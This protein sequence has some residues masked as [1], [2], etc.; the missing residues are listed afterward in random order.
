MSNI[1][2]T[3]W[4]KVDNLKD[5]D[6]DYSDNPEV[7]DEM[8][9]LMQFREPEKK[10]IYIKLDNDVI[11]FFKKTNKHYQVTINKVLKAYKQSVE[12]HR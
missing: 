6:I 2:K 1:L 3:N 10:G 12:K 9:Q 4:D 11:E 7:T 5:E 8:F